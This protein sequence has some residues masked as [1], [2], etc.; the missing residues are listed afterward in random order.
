MTYF[1]LFSIQPSDAYCIKWSLLTFPFL[2]CFTL[3]IGCYHDSPSP[4]PQKALDLLIL[5]LDDRDTLVRR[6]AVEALGK[7][8]DLKSKPMLLGKLDDPEPLVREA[9]ARSLGWLSGL[10]PETRSRLTMLLQDDDM[11]VRQAASQ[12]LTRN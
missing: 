11:S 2:A 1:S 7:I 5:L 4:E 10:D 6:N 12:A 9:A 3:T 8:G